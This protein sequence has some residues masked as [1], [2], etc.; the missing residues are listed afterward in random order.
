MT[1]TAFQYIF[2][3]AETLSMNRRATVAQTVARDQTVR[4]VSRGGQVWRFEVKLPDGLTW[5][6]LRPYVEALDKADRYTAGNVSI[7]QTGTSW[8]SGYQG[9]ATAVTGFNATFTTGDSITLTSTGTG[10]SPGKYSFKSGD[11]IQ[12]GT[13]GRVYSVVDNVIYPNT[14][15]KL[16]RPIIESAGSYALTVGPNVKWQVICTDFPDWTF[17][18]RNLVSWSG[19]FKFQESYV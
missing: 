7:N 8:L 15:V 11:F 6:E 9:E 13:G 19:T 17:S 4:S 1:T 18:Q 10:L 12:L 5:T 2:D 3:K 16:N 14:T